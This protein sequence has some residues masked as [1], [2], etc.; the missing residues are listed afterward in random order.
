MNAGR[1]RASLV[2]SVRRLRWWELLPEAALVVGLTIFA[3]TERSA[4]TSAF[5]SGRAVALMIVAVIAW[6]ALRIVL[7]Q[8]HRL[9]VART[10]LFAVAAAGALAV[11]VLPAY[12]N[13]RVVEAFP[14]SASVSAAPEPVRLRTGSFAGI[15]HRASGT[16]SLYR[17]ADGR[18]VVGLEMFD[19]Q[20]GPNYDVYLV[21]GTDRHDRAD[22]VRLDD[23]RGNQ[24]TQYYELPADV[25]VSNGPWT[26][27][28]W[29]ETFGVPVA[30]AT[31]I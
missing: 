8:V 10:L 31:P 4:A 22:G 24:G 28:V 14:L 3:I 29:C 19:I 9:R 15:D 7:A 20:P 25:V 5:R 11:V 16:V 21:P 6:I 1:I 13:E 17:A 27:L 26:V 12:R 30:N 23:L 18:H 2:A